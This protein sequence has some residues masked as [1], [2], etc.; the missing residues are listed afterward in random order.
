MET[1]NGKY[2]KSDITRERIFRAAMAVMGEK[3]YQGATI[4]E[5]CER[6]NVAVGS[7]YRYFQ[8]KPDLLRSVYD[9]GDERMQA[10]APE[11]SE[12]SWM[13][14]I[15]AFVTNYARLNAETG[16]STM[17]ILYNPENTWFARTRPM[18]RKLE[19]LIAGAQAAGEL[20]QLPDAEE[21]T[22][23]LFVCMRGIC[24]DWCI[25]DGT[26]D[27]EERMTHQMSILLSAF[28]E[29]K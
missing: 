19:S 20:Q 4:R 14:R 3:G 22:E 6:A 29:K 8:A 27:L 7:F 2:R 11:L 24:Y 18:Q 15:S 23:F 26:Y 17:R 10:E 28:C 12:A 25:A 9:A 13:T 5:I 16:L 21:M 1:P